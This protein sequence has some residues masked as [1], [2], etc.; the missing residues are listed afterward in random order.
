[1]SATVPDIDSVSWPDFLRRFRWR[2]GEHMTIIGPTGSG[3]TT[4]AMELMHRRK[5]VVILACKPRDSRLAGLLRNDGY[6][7]MREWNP[8]PLDERVILWPKVERPADELR[9]REV[10]GEALT[11]IY[12]SGGW[13]VF[14]DEVRYLTEHLKLPRLVNILWLHGR[15]L[16][17]SVV[18]GTQ[19]PTHIPLL[20]F[21]QATHL[22][23]FRD[24]DDVNL[25]RLGSLGAASNRTVRETVA[26][27]AHHEILYVNTRSGEL[28]RTLPVVQ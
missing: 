17:I 27:L 4:L 3:K 1:M 26:T 9:Q 7:L 8:T 19:R 15:S 22:F 21:D 25:R 10:F 28:I 16:D 5:Y 13:T 23:L 24:N 2:Q 6:R 14:M 11:N 20:A 12:R 18:A